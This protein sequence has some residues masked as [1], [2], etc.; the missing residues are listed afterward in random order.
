MAILGWF[1]MMLTKRL[2]LLLMLAV[3]V[4]GL[5]CQPTI[6]QLRAQPEQVAPAAAEPSVRPPVVAGPFYP[7]DPEQLRS[8]IADFMAEAEI[9][10]LSGDVIA[11]M[12]PH[13]GYRYSGAV[14][15]H[16]FKV[17]QG[18]EY[19]TVVLIGLSH[20]YAVSGG[21][22]ISGKDYWRTPLGRVAIDTELRTE[23]VSASDSLHIDDAPHRWEHSLEVELPFLQTVLSDFSIVPILMTDFSPDNTSRVA[24]AIAE[25]LV[26]RKVLIVAS[27]DM[28]HY[29]AAE[30]AE[31]VDK[32]ML[33]A[34]ATLD[35]AEVYATDEELM[36]EGV[37]NLHCTL[38]ALGPLVVA[39]KV[40]KSLGADQARVLKYSNSVQADPTTA[41][42]CVGYGA[43]AFV[44]TDQATA[45]K[46]DQA[47]QQFLLKLA[48]DTIQAHLAG[49]KAPRADTDE[50]AMHQQRAV[51]VTLHKNGR[52][53]G[54][55]GQLVARQSLI[56]AVRDA[57]TSAATQDP[58]FQPVNLD[59]LDNIEI[60]I[61]VLSPPKE[62]DDPSE[63]EVGKHGVIVSQGLHRGV[64]LPQVAP[65]QGWDRETML[66]HLCADKAHL[67]SDAWRHGATLQVFTAQVFSEHENE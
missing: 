51:F 22:A 25:V 64:F 17:V 36:T 16:A 19:P 66:R 12:A 63:I 26:Q 46:L 28:C 58:R 11:L 35:S 65:E 21:G 55:I 41:N 40:A 43:V 5:G 52:L 38:C 13:A 31:R 60:Q 7:A 9:P 3:A 8:A 10:E 59:E 27:T 48:R 44:D 56:D 53:R 39:M 24:E 34:I 29:P 42:R 57:A 33:E 23:L 30:Q 18:C 45:S 4:G 67:P 6:K 2:H 15:A 47:Q 37:P 50:L 49:N 54:C 62:I 32:A 20:Q 14:A 61:S 1:T